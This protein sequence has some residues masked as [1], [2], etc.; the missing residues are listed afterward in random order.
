[1]LD[2]YRKLMDLLDARERRRFWL[3]M[4]LLVVMGLANMLGVASVMPFLAVLSDPGIVERNAWLSWAYGL[5]G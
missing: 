3:L 4:V 5:S 1:M 2:A